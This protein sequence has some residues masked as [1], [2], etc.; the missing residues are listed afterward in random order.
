MT[1]S[2]NGADRPAGGGRCERR[3]LLRLVNERMR[4]LSRT[5]GWAT[6]EHWFSFQCECGNTA[7]CD[8]RVQMSLAEYERVRAGRRG[9]AVAPG[10]ELPDLE[11][12]LERS[13]RY[14][15][16]GKPGPSTF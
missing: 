13:E 10:H 16:V 6:A 2:G 5:A 12:V 4:V 7:G 14:L 1:M 15:V 3:S 11:Q 8:A 9:Y